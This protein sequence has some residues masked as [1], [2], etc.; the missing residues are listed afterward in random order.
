MYFDGILRDTNRDL[1][2][3]LSVPGLSMQRLH[4]HEHYGSS[5][6]SREEKKPNK[7]PVCPLHT[8]FRSSTHLISSMSYTTSQVFLFNIRIENISDLLIRSLSQPNH[9]QTIS[10]SPLPLP[11]T[12]HSPQ[13]QSPWSQP[14]CKPR[15]NSAKRVESTGIFA[16]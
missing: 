9:Q 13:N 15:A 12:P 4:T 2:G 1:V 8:Y 5:P 7:W 11:Q 6:L 16:A 14:P 3:G 10:H